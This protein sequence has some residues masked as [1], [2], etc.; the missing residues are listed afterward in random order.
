MKAKKNTLSQSEVSEIK[1]S[2]RK[3]EKD[4]GSAEVQIAQLTSRIL[5]LTQHIIANRGDKHSR[6]GLV[7]M[8]SKRRRLLKYLRRTDSEK[9]T[10]VLASLGIRK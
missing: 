5:H 7:G 6:R 1:D 9:H 3:H 10:H 8:V 4:V 2:L